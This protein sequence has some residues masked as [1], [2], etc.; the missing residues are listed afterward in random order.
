[1]TDKEI[2]DKFWIKNINDKLVFRGQIFNRI[3]L[4]E[5]TEPYYTYLLNRYNDSKSLKETII[6][7]KSNINERPKCKTCGKEVKFVN[8]SNTI[9][10]TYCCPRCEMLDKDVINKSKNTKKIK[11]NDENYSNR[12]KYKETC[13]NKFGC[14]SPFGNKE[15]I[16]K[17]E[18][19]KLKRYNNKHFV[20][21]EKS[22]QTCIERYGVDSPTK[23]LE[24]KEKIK[25]TCLKRYGADIP[26]KSDKIKEKLKQTCLKRYGVTNGGGSK[27]AIEKIKETKKI[28]YGDENYN[29]INKIK[30]TNIDKYGVPNVLLIYENIEKNK[31]KWINKAILLYP[32][33]QELILKNG[34]YYARHLIEQNTKYLHYGDINFNNPTK[35]H[36]TMK[37]NNSF[38][39][40]KTEDLAYLYLSL[41]YPDTIR[42]YR[43]EKR[44]PFNCD[45]YIPC[46]DLFIECNFHWTHGNH[47]FDPNSKEDQNKLYELQHKNGKYYETAGITWTQRDPLKVKTAK[48]NNLNYKIFWNLDEL[49]EW[50]K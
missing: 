27:Q 9:F 31:K 26:L 35:R 47:I 5:K 17:S 24:I 49:I 20:N 13:I 33:K 44:Y 22:K 11:Y 41:E 45:F 39:R 14:V 29:N 38:A 21:K 3:I 40:S 46:L 25:Q 19:T 8:S 2:I 1:M 34:P 16:K 4:K 6:R 23:L 28:K 43:D 32:N 37:E 7:I 12:E 42:Q 10:N 36:K 15:V 48:Q 30:S 18:E 50:L